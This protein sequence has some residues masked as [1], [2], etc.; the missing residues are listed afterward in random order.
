M[1][2]ALARAVAPAIADMDR[3][4][5]EAAR[6]IW[7]DDS[8]TAEQLADPRHPVFAQAVV[9]EFSIA[10]SRMPHI[11]RKVMNRASSAAEDLNVEPFQGLIEVIQNADDLKAKEVRFALRTIG[12]QQQLLIVHDG[13]P[14]TCG[15]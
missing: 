9:E 3:A 2:D 11:M 5:R 14:V 15:H 1:S 8:V 7:D 4:G 10:L 6:L 13:R 12:E